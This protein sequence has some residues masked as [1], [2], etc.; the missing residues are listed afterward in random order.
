MQ[1]WLHFQ[2][3]FRCQSRP[4]EPAVDKGVL[5]V[6]TL[7]QPAAHSVQG[8]GHCWSSH[9]HQR[10]SCP[11][12]PAW[13]LVCT[14]DVALQLPNAW[15]ELRYSGDHADHLRVGFPLFHKGNNGNFLVRLWGGIGG[16]KRGPH[17][18]APQRGAPAITS[19]APWVCAG[20]FSSYSSPSWA[21][22]P[23]RGCVS[24]HLRGQREWTHAGLS[25]EASWLLF[26]H[27]LIHPCVCP[28]PTS[29]ELA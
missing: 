12:T 13:S 26:I 2:C 6:G 22:C 15:P 1:L 25:K 16:S 19:W 23:L 28:V 3:G 20:L 24:G 4:L 17:I 10:A 14:S 27:S 11:K 9:Q 29:P 8:Q 7:S 5:L 18:L 21:N